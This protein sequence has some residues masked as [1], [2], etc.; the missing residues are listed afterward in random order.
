M[1]FRSFSTK[2]HQKL[3]T[4]PQRR[5]LHEK[6]QAMLDADV[7]DPCEPGQVKCVSP[8]TFMQKTHKS[9]GLT[10]DELQHCVNDECIRNG[11]EPQFDLPS[12]PRPQTAADNAGDKEDEPKWRICQN[13]L[14]IN[15]VMQVAP[16]PQGDIRRKQQ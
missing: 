4:P 3:L 6:L 8:T 13:V 11:L 5:Y 7:I 2:V 16:M 9:A 1:L 14:Q 12:R 15:K 10:L